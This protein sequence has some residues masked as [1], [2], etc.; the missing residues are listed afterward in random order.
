MK[1][2]YFL[3][4]GQ[5]KLNKGLIHQY[6][7]TMLSSNGHDQALKA[8][9]RLSD[10]SFDVILTSPLIRARQTAQAVAEATGKPIEEVALFEELRRPR[11]VYGKN[12]LS[13]TSMKAMLS[14]YWN[15]GRDNWHY[16]DEE[17]LE[18]FHA[19]SR[20]ALEYLAQRPEE[21]ILVVTHRGLMAALKER[22]MHD[23]MDTKKQYRH[24]L[25]KNVTIGNCCYMTAVWTPQGENGDTLTGT[26]ALE[27]GIVCPAGNYLDIGL[28]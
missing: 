4:H 20:R 17:N 11:I 6:P 14:I 13:W 19:R 8:A 15:A 18:E 23:G 24:A 26:W 25:I 21:K 10:E 9:Q 1:T 12:W 27:D 28:G 16:S 3:R 22:I 7:D 5:T 2:V